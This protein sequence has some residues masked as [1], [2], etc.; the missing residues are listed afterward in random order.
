MLTLLLLA[1]STSNAPSD[2]LNPSEQSLAAIEKANE[3]AADIETKSGTIAQIARK[4]LQQDL[5]EKEAVDSIG[6]ALKALQENMKVLEKQVDEAGQ[7]LAFPKDQ[8]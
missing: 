6:I 4:A 7:M 1:C 8:R 2:A 5:P 3:V